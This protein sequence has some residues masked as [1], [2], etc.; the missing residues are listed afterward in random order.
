MPP[1]DFETLS[2]IVEF[3]FTL[4]PGLKERQEFFFREHQFFRILAVEALSKADVHMLSHCTLTVD[5]ALKKMLEIRLDHLLTSHGVLQ[6]RVS[7]LEEILNRLLDIE[8][9]SSAHE[10]LIRQR[11]VMKKLGYEGGF[12]LDHRILRNPW[13]LSPGVIICVSVSCDSKFTGHRVP[14]RVSLSGEVA[15]TVA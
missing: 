2:H 14:C 6:A 3:D 1:D 7:R 11:D 5:I 10:T 8:S 12:S 13:N 9:G 4:S 15:R